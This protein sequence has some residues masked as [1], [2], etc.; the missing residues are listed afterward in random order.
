MV[1]EYTGSRAELATQKWLIDEIL[2][3]L[4][5]YWPIDATVFLFKYPDLVVFWTAGT[6]GVKE[7]ARFT[8]LIGIRL[9]KA[10]FFCQNRWL[11]AVLGRCPNRLGPDE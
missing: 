3:Y 10:G 8:S 2:H 7:W 4:G 11:R 9:D 5:Q 6:A 1:G